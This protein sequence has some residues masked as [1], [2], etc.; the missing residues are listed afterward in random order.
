MTSRAIT[1]GREWILGA[2]ILYGSADLVVGWM[3]SFFFCSERLLR[4]SL[5][6]RR[7]A[8]AAKIGSEILNLFQI[9][10]LSYLGGLVGGS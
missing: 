9:S 1:Y 8:I 7:G 10:K 4:R 3:L 5:T 6:P 2:S